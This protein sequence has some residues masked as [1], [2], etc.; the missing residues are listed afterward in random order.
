MIA[1]LAMYDWP[2]QSGHWDALW[3]V[4]R[5]GLSTR[6]I[7][8]P[9]RLTR[10]TGLWDVWQSPDL[11][12]GQTCGLP[13]RTRLHGNVTLL[14]AFDHGLPGCLPGYYNSV[15]VVR[16]DATGDLAD[17]LDRTLAYNG[18]DSESGWAAA[19]AAALGLGRPFRRKVYSGAHRAS[20]RMVAAG[21]ADIAAIDAETW[22]LVERH[23]PETAGALRVLAR[24][25]PTPGLPLIAAPGQDAAAIVGA[26]R[27]ALV[28]LPEDTRAALHIEDFVKI[29]ATAYLAVPPPPSLSQT[30]EHA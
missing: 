25:E 28:R 2:E 21:E 3:Q 19:Q 16:R 15:L 20:A 10:D 22:R 1:S 11:V 27:A 29:P 23:L 24:T 14:G 7:A 26:I 30:M 8:A 12:L 13:Y 4:L 5:E 18:L 9:D 6:G 17:F